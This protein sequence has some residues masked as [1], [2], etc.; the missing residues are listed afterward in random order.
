MALGSEMLTEYFKVLFRSG[1]FAFLRDFKSGMISETTATYRWGE[2]N[3]RYR[4]GTSDTQVIYDTLL[5]S[6]R[7]SEYQ[8]PDNLNPSV[9]LDIGGNIGA[10]SIYFARKFPGARILSFEPV[11]QN[12]ALLEEN[13]SSLTNVSTFPTALG[14][15]DGEAE[16]FGPL[17][18][19]NL[20]G[21]SFFEELKGDAKPIRVK[22]KHAGRYIRSL[23]I[24]KIDLIKID[25]E[26]AEFDIL[27]SF[28]EGVLS[29]VSWVVGELHGVRDFEL[30]AYLS[31]WFDIDVRKT[32]GK[33]YF[34]FNACSHSFL[35]RA[36]KFGWKQRR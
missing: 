28:D 19:D 27:S 11:P 34:M 1:S 9:I 17:E 20:G 8:V 24:D 22:T 15:K 12:Y 21:F 29:N 36:V 35:E 4:P 6:G 25:T 13:V 7:K 16:I 26:G 5:K 31:K 14:N 10:A 23:G 30:L 33:R 18:R 3:I 2:T 32:L